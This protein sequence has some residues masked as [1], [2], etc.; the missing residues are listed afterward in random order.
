MEVTKENDLY[1]SCTLPCVEV[2]TVGGGAILASQRT[3]LESLE[4]AGPDQQDGMQND[5][6]KL[7]TND[8]VSSH[9]KL[10]RSKLKLYGGEPR[11]PTQFQREA[12]KVEGSIRFELHGNK[13]KPL[14]RDFV[15]CSNIL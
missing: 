14:T 11:K 9:M 8:L 7:T 10:N 5:S 3:C 1:V 15:Q 6:I 2:G 4:C 13:L 12:G